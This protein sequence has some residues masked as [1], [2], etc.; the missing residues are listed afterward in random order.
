MATGTQAAPTTASKVE[1]SAVMAGEKPVNKIVG[2]TDNTDAIPEEFKVNENT[3][4]K[5]ITAVAARP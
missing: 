2:N 5:R 3:T 1:K 4:Q